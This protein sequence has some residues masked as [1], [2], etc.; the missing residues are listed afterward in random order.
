MKEKKTQNR[1]IMGPTTREYY[2][3]NKT[4]FLALLGMLIIILP[5]AANAA[6]ENGGADANA[7]PKPEVVAERESIPSLGAQD[8]KRKSTV[9]RSPPSQ[10]GEI[11]GA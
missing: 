8:R 4:S 5:I 7:K 1:A 11:E 10:R 6:A 3:Q 2:A 9:E